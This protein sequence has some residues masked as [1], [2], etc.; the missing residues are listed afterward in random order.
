[1]ARLYL[2][3][4]KLRA[5]KTSASLLLI[6]QTKP[7]TPPFGVPGGGNFKKS[8]SGKLLIVIVKF[9]KAGIS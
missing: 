5:K 4:A 9:V 6:Y 3:A 8:S 1:M 7:I 2:N